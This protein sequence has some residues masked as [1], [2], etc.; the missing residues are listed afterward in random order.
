[1]Q[2]AGFTQGEIDGLLGPDLSASAHREPYRRPLQRTMVPALQPPPPLPPAK[3]NIVDQWKAAIDARRI[4]ISGE[5]P[6]KDINNTWSDSEDDDEDSG[7]EIDGGKSRRRR[8]KM[9]SSRKK[10]KTTRK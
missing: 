4:G 3:E 9:K 8:R 5:N 2:V 7:K 10:R 1:M 6:G